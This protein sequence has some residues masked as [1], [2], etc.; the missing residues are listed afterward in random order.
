VTVSLLN[1]NGIGANAAASVG[2][3][4]GDIDNSR[5]GTNADV[6]AVKANSGLITD[7]TNFRTDVDHSGAITASDILRAKGSV[8][9]T[10]P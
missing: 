7:G 6:I 9:L 5:T 3:L 8:G 10:I 1:V 2:F 4:V